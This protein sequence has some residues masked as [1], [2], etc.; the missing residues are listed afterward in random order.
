MK[1]WRAETG[2]E[3]PWDPAGI[4]ERPYDHPDALRL[5]RALFDEQAARY[6]FADPVAADPG[7][8]APPR[9]LFL[10]AYMADVPCACG[11]Y[12][13]YDPSPGTVEIKKLYTS[14]AMRGRGLGAVVLARLEQHAGDHGATTAILETGVRNSAA[15]SL[16]QH[17]HYQPTARYV[18]GRD[19]AINR[20]FIK[21][22]RPESPST[23]G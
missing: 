15:L 11:G 20:A 17:A 7:G 21:P 2:P 12:R 5:V 22:L 1:A 10:V 18:S 6:G 4:I 23:P 13:L 14:P 16:F 8:Y 3:N 9:G 19:P